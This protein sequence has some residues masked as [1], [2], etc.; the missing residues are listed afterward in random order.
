M[1]FL[2]AFQFIYG[3]HFENGGKVDCISA[4]CLR[5]Q[6]WHLVEKEKR[7]NGEGREIFAITVSVSKMLCSNFATLICYII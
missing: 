6:R 4:D 5:A 7:N 1:T 2:T 3:R